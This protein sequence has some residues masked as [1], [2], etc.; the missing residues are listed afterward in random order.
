MSYF[1]V[2][3]KYVL[4]DQ[5]LG[6]RWLIL[7]SEKSK[8]NSIVSSSE[9]HYNVLHVCTCIVERHC[10]I[11]YWIHMNTRT[12]AYPCSGKTEVDCIIG[13]IYL[14]ANSGNTR[15]GANTCITSSKFTFDLI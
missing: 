8:L 4:V 5:F 12:L 11:G 2:L 13:L 3:A 14:I 9:S 7:R 10:I 6:Y 15:G 1:I